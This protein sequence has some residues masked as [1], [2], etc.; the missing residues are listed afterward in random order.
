MNVF[1]VILPI[2]FLSKH[3][4]SVVQNAANERLITSLREIQTKIWM[5]L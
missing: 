2:A 5:I 3:T 1:I 4:S